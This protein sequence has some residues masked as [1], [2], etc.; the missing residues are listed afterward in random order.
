[1]NTYRPA[2]TTGSTKNPVTF[3]S[4][5]C[6]GEGLLIDTCLYSVYLSSSWASSRTISWVDGQQT[7]LLSVTGCSCL[8][9]WAPEAPAPLCFLVQARKNTFFPPVCTIHAPPQQLAWV[10]SPVSMQDTAESWSGL[11][12]LS[13]CLTFRDTHIPMYTFCFWLM[14][15]LVSPCLALRDMKT[16]RQV[17]VLSLWLLARSSLVLADTVGS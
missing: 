14:A 16:H 4:R 15:P 17:L 5:V 13:R 1:M 11:L 7:Q 12:S 6:Q 8:C 2:L 10:Y 3:P 9:V